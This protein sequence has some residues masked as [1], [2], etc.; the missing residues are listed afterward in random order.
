VILQKVYLKEIFLDIQ[1]NIEFHSSGSKL[2]TTSD[3]Y[4]A[5]VCFYVCACIYH[6]HTQDILYVC[7]C[8]C[9]GLIIQQDKISKHNVKDSPELHEVQYKTHILVSFSFSGIIH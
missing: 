1:L 5:P 4:T 3:P 9:Q 2:L 8:V 7:V 6:T